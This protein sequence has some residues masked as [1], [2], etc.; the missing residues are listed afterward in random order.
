ML[1]HVVPKKLEARSSSCTE[2][3][4]DD[5]PMI[6]HGFWILPPGT[7]KPA[8]KRQSHRFRHCHPHSF[9]IC[10]SHH[11]YLDAIV[12]SCCVHHFT[13]LSSFSQLKSMFFC[14]C[15]NGREE[16]LHPM[17]PCPEDDSVRR[18]WPAANVLRSDSWR[19]SEHRTG[20][21]SD[22]Q[23]LWAGCPE[24]STRLKIV[25][26][27]KCLWSWSLCLQHIQIWTL[28][29]IVSFF[30]VVGA[31]S[32]VGLQVRKPNNA[33]RLPYVNINNEFTQTMISQIRTFGEV[34]T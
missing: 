7:S 24:L 20:S 10:I 13:S 15:M 32:D 8:T 6:S 1:Y 33:L 5:P 17:G 21:T 29:D 26:P 27:E 14:A 34:P 2:H 23:G 28:Y 11:P 19:N 4:F 25:D 9:L 18:A 22:R 30:W 3:G 16:R 12:S 31:G